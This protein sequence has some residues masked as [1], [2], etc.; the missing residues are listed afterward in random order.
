[1]PVE[2]ASAAFPFQNTFGYCSGVWE[3]FKQFLGVLV[4]RG[5]HLKVYITCGKP[6][7]EQPWTILHQRIFDYLPLRCHPLPGFLLH[8]L[9]VFL[10]GCVVLRVI[11][12]VVGWIQGVREKQHPLKIARTIDIV[13]WW[14]QFYGSMQITQVYYYGGR[15]EHCLSIV[16]C[17]CGNQP[18]WL[19]LQIFGCFCFPPS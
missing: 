8:M 14:G 3:W 11:Q 10:R 5:N 6:I 18:Q 1:M 12:V 7:T 17:K 9:L 15:L 16:Q 2:S 13:Y 4:P 19:D